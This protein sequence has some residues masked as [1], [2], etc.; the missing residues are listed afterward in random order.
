MKYIS[1][2][3]ATSLPTPQYPTTTLRLK[4]ARLMACVWATCLLLSANASAGFVYGDGTAQI[5]R[6]EGYVNSIGAVF[7]TNS[8]TEHSYRESSVFFLPNWGITTIHGLREIDTDPN[9]LYGNLSVTLGSNFFT[10]PGA[11]MQVSEVFIHPLYNG[12]NNGY[13][14]ALLYFENPSATVNPLNFYTGDIAVGMEAD[15]VGFGRLQE[16]GSSTIT[17][18]GDLRAGNN[19]IHEVDALGPNYVGTIFEKSTRPNY[20]PD[21]MGATS[22]HSGGLLSINHEIAAITAFTSG[23]AG[24]F[25]FTGYNIIDAFS[26]E[27]IGNSVASKPPTSV[28]EPTSLLLLLM[29]SPFLAFIRRRR[30]VIWN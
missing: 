27:W 18:T 29:S 28:P 19:V 10:A 24:T 25:Q 7:G 17:L 5:G 13:D 22:G 14:L 8:A 16:F 20:R 21:Q 1:S 23:P 6:A 9:S 4:L 12:T 2:C 30:R 15:I 3:H 11:T 26:S